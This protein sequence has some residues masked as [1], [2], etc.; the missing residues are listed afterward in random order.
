[1]PTSE[2]HLNNIVDPVR[3]K[4]VA[5]TPEEAVRQATIRFLHSNRGIPTGL[6]KVEQVIENAPGDK[7]ADL[8]IYS[9]TGK[10]WMLVECK[11]P[12]IKIDQ[13]T[14]DQIANYNRFVKAPYL[15]VTNGSDHFCMEVVDGLV[16]FI[17]DL[18]IW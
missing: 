9:T 13:T 14:F 12:S 6:M 3:K 4:S 5:N 10:P 11:A 8:I 15:F 18:P 7:R 16:T 17:D 2:P 1:M